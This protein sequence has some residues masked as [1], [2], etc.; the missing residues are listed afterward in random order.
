MTSV[1]PHRNR[2]LVQRQGNYSIIKRYGQDQSQHHKIPSGQAHY[3][4]QT[5]VLLMQ[6]LPLVAL[7]LI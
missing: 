4:H 1:E 7:V 2:T 6:F 5:L 3:S